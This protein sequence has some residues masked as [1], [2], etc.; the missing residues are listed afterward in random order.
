MPVRFSVALAFAGV[1]GAP[2]AL[3]AQGE[4]KAVDTVT[5]SDE[6]GVWFCQLPRYVNRL[7]AWGLRPFGFT[8][9]I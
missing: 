2:P 5:D 6:V 4:N 1:G 3:D 7:H 9:N 8:S